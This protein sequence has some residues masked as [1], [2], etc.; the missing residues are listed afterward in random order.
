MKLKVLSEAQI[1]ELQ[2]NEK[3][4]KSN[5][6]F[7]KLASIIKHYNDG[8]KPSKED[9]GYYIYSR[10]MLLLW[11]G[12]SHYGSHGD[13]SSAISYSAFS[14]SGATFGARLAIR[15]Y[16]LSQFII[17]NYESLYKDL[18]MEE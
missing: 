15:D 10:K 18:W 2:V 14:H 5:E 16:K 7:A 11:G 8:W 6:A 9:L 17:K 4:Q 13:L 12:Y 3:E 1:S